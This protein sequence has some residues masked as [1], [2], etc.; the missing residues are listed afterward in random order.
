MISARAGWWPPNSSTTISISGRVTT[1]AASRVIDFA[2]APSDGDELDPQIRHRRQLNRRTEH[3]LVFVAVAQDQLHHAAAHGTASEQGN[4]YR[5]QFVPVHV[6]DC[7]CQ[8]LAVR[9]P[10]SAWPTLSA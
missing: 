8:A 7:P 6:R 9:T 5:F 10:I 4:P 3:A 2:G 1:A